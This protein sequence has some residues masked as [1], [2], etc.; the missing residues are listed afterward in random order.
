MHKEVDKV[1]EEKANMVVKIPNEWTTTEVTLAI[2][3]TFRDDV[4]D[5]GQILGLVEIVPNKKW[6]PYSSCWVF[7]CI[8]HLIHGNAIFDILESHAYQ[9]YHM[10]GLLSTLE[11]EKSEKG[12]TAAAAGSIL[13]L[14]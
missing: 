5:G 11:S 9:K 2:G 7:L 14:D 10:L 6:C 8:S 3:D 13:D 12:G 1:A 4:S